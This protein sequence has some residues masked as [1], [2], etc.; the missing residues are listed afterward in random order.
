MYGESPAC[1]FLV[2]SNAGPGGDE[3]LARWYMEMHGPDA[4]AAGSF[5]ALHRYQA[6]GPYAARFL[7]VWEGAFTSIE[8]VRSRIVPGSRTLKD[9]GRITSDLVVVWSGFHF[10][11]DAEIAPGAATVTTLTLVEGGDFDAPGSSAYRYGR[12]SLFES[13]EDLE[14]VATEWAG[15]G[16]EAMAPHGPYQNL[17]DHPEAWPPEGTDT[18]EPWISHWRPIG[19]LW[20]DGRRREASSGTT[21]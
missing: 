13:G 11:T 5:S 17:F 18:S 19:S 10:L 21:S 12:L 8:D 6:L 15:R 2:F 9:R 20:A 3:A 4:F 1:V 14:A 7:A 16:P